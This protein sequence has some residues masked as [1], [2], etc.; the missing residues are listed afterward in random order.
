[1]FFDALGIE[2]EYEPEGFETSAGPYLPDFRIKTGNARSHVWIWF[3]V[4]PPD[5][6]PDRRH[7]SFAWDTGTH[8]AIARG[9][10]RDYHDQYAA[11]RLTLV[12]PNAGEAEQVGFCPLKAGGAALYMGPTCERRQTYGAIDRAYAA[13]RSERFGT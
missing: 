5:S 4:K 10:A 7:T 2:W 3:E 8:L 1:V 9:M 13:A 6:P 11:R 12:L